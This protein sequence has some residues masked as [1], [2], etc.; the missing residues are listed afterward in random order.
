[1]QFIIRGEEV[2]IKII[3]IHCIHNFGSVF[4][5]S[6]L[7]RFLIDNGYDVEIIDYHPAYFTSGRNKIRTYIG[8][9]MNYG[10]YNR[11]KR[12][13]DRF[14]LQHMELTNTNYK[15]FEELKHND[16]AADIFIAGG[17]QLWNDYHFSGRDPAFKLA[18]ITKGK[19]WL[20]VPVWGAIISRQL[21]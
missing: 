20:L 6:A 12:K 9:L 3:T 19:K 16:N 15:E 4:Q 13:F 2:K 14:K 7:Q 1:M 21:K 11:R 18:F 10:A 8:R 5:A 17:D